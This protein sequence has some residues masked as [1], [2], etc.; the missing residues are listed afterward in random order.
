MQP[1]GFITAE[2]RLREERGVKVLL[3]GPPGVGKTS[4]LR[5]LD[6]KATLFLE[7]ESG[8]LAVID[9]PVDTVRL[10]DWPAARDVAVRV[11]GANPSF[12]ATSCYSDAHLRGV[13]GPLPDHERYTTIFIDSVTALARL[14]FRW[15]EQQPEAFAPSGK[16][17][18]R[19]A[20][21]LLARE[22]IAFLGQL[23]HA[24]RLNV[25]M[26]AILEWVVDEWG[27]GEW[28]IQL[29]GAKT[30]RELPGRI[31]E[32]IVYQFLQFKDDE[33]SKPPMRAFV[34]TSPNDWSLPAKDRSGKLKQL[35]PPDLGKLIA[36]LARS[37]TVPPEQAMLNLAAA[38]E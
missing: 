20:Y 12:P 6:P 15:C 34:C 32:V 22:L 35:E 1:K 23:Q 33:P 37:A 29:E 27:R 21:G 18:I 17:D 3:L 9:V 2:E 13:G 28:G 8:D 14:C 19:N 36:K 4:Q 25:V 26:V 31:D 38:A 10:P 7:I 30:G 24:R 16:K 5:T 11:G